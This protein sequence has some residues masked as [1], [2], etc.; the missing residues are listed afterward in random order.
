[1]SMM[2]ELTYFLSLQ[3]KQVKDGIFISQT[4]YIYDLLKKFD[5]TDCSFAKTPMATTTKLDLNTKES[6]V[7][8][9]SY[10]AMVRLTFIFNRKY[11]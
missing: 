10:R 11:T 1:M 5:L 6:E 8:I 3:V 7:D 4:V 9:S 2:G